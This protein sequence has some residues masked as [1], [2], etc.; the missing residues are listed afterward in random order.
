VNKETTDQEV[1]KE[2]ISTRIITIG[3]TAEIIEIVHVVLL[4]GRIDLEVLM[5][6]KRSKGTGE[7]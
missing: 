4:N 1:Q 3:E 5:Q 6:E 7:Y 2:E